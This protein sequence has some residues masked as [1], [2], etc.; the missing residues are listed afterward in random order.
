MQPGPITALC[1]PEYPD[2][3]IQYR[4]DVCL[5]DTGWGGKKTYRTYDKGGDMHR[6][7]EKAK[8]EAH[9]TLSLIEQGDMALPEGV[10]EI[11]IQEGDFDLGADCGDG[12]FDS[13]YTINES[14]VFKRIR[15]SKRVHVEVL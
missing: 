2:A 15:V 10:Y 7:F 13:E 14:H 4:V 12:S 8:A 5:V 1:S 9:L 11:Q 6:D 3:D